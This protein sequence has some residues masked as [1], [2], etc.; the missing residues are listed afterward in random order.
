M[1]RIRE[2]LNVYLNNLKI[3][4]KD[5]LLYFLLCHASIGSY[6]YSD[7]WNVYS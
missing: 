4:E 2:K 3:K 1:K 6:R 7:L 5:F